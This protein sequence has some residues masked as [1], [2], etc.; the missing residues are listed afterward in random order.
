MNK[1]VKYFLSCAVG[2]V[3]ALFGAGG[4]LVAVPIF[5]GMGLSQ[6]QAQASALSV[7]LPLSVISASVYYYMGYFSIKDAL[8][9]IPFGIVG[10][11]LGTH[12]I[13]KIPDKILRKLF[14]AFMIY[15][16]IRMLTR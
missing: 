2:L 14:S 3:N 11:L 13:K 6:K 15:T 16:G 12:L 8:G 9:Y 7:I 4:G 1:P 5:K 10:S